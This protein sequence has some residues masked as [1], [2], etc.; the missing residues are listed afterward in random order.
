[1]RFDP[2]MTNH[3][4][5]DQNTILAASVEVMGEDKGMGLHIVKEYVTAHGGQISIESKEGKGTTVIFTIPCASES[6]EIP[7]RHAA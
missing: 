6:A 4:P 1:M 5:Y 7:I 3:G 2:K